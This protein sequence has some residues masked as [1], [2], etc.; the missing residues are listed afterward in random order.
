MNVFKQEAGFTDSLP[1]G[2]NRTWIFAA[3]LSW[4]LTCQTR[5][6]QGLWIFNPSSEDAPS[7]LPIMSLKKNMSTLSQ[8]SHLM[9]LWDGGRGRYFSQTLRV[10]PLNPREEVHK[11][12]ESTGRF[13]LLPNLLSLP[14][15]SSTATWGVRLIPGNVWLGVC[16]CVRHAK[17]IIGWKLPGSLQLG[18]IHDS[19]YAQHRCSWGNSLFLSQCQ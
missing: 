19:Q 12:E 9:W 14:L 8:H 10:Y 17:N 3:C 15:P 5:W 16:V 18:T 2:K 1:K 7:S 6:E 4:R 11:R 13:S